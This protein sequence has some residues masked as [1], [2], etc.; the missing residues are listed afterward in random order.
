MSRYAALYPK[1][2]P[3]LRGVRWL[4]PV[5]RAWL[6]WKYRGGADVSRVEFAGMKLFLRPGVFNPAQFLTTGTL[7]EAVAREAIPPGARWLELGTGS[8]AIALCAAR[9]GAAVIATDINPEAVACARENA[10][11]LGLAVEVRAGD[12]FVPVAGERFDVVVFHPPYFAGAQSQG[13]GPA[14]HYG[15]VPRR[16]AEGLAEHL[17]PGGVGM[18]LLSSNGDCAAYL[19]ALEAAGFALEIAFERELIMELAVV[20]RVKRGS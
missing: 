11:A 2:R 19:E 10:A 1:A 5:Y 16:F 15:D 6:Q 13:L 18:L 12:L 20:Y 14:W 4:Q 7:V 17:A 8:G 9:R 3:R